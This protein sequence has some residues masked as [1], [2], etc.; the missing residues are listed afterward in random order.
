MARLDAAGAGAFAAWPSTRT[1]TVTASAAATPAITRRTHRAH[2]KSSDECID[3]YLCAIS[4]SG[5]F[6]HWPYIS[7]S[8]NSTHLKS[9]SCAFFSSAAVERHADLPRPRER[10]RIFDRRFVADHVRGRA[11][12]ALDDVQLDRCGSCPARSN[13]VLSL[14]P[15]TSMTS[16]SP[17]QRADRLAHPRIDRRRPGI[18]Q[19]DVADRAG[20]LVRKEDRARALKDLKRIRHVVRARH[21]GQIALDLRIALEPVLLILFFLRERFRLVRNLVAFDDA[22]ARRHRADRAEREHR[23]RRHRPVR[24][25]RSAMAGRAMCA[26][27]S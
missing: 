24:P 19:V 17:S 8:T 4:V 6:R 13:H 5:F 27:R 23:C 16:V 11:R 7:S 18:L 3:C 26:S 22:H 20:V 12:V 25:G 2:K 21:T 9:R 14:K 1:V 15:V 10:L